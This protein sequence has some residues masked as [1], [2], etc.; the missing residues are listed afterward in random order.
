MG[1]LYSLLPLLLYSILVV[2]HRSAMWSALFALINQAVSR[3]KA[4]CGN[5]QIMPVQKERTVVDVN[6]LVLFV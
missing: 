6:V 4:K 2:T 1:K 3:F 5:A